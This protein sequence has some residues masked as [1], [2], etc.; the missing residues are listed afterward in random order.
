MNLRLHML[1]MRHL[2]EDVVM[3]HNGVKYQGSAEYHPVVPPHLLPHALRAFVA[4]KGP[5]NDA[6]LVTHDISLEERANRIQL[7]KLYENQGER[8]IHAVTEVVESPENQ[9]ARLQ[10]VFSNVHAHPY[11]A[12]GFSALVASLLQNT[13]QKAARP[14]ELGAGELSVVGK[15]YAEL[16][17]PFLNTKR[18]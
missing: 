1:L 7:Q 15:Q 10:A 3:I 8:L 9:E 6:R 2:P 16:A 4:V 11:N 14:V 12:H 18:V 17:L 5:Q 13:M